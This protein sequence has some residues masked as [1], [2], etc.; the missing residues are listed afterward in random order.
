MIPHGVAGAVPA[1]TKPGPCPD[2]QTPAGPCG[3]RQTLLHG[4]GRLIV[5]CTA[6]T[7]RHAADNSR[8]P[9]SPAA[10][11]TPIRRD[12]AGHPRHGS[13]VSIGRIRYSWLLTVRDLAPARRCFGCPPGRVRARSGRGG[14]YGSG[15]AERVPAIGISVPF[16]HPGLP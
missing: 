5:I 13:A 11:N 1:L 4:G 16:D 2:G 3:E 9:Q 6:T 15:S 8:D 12:P 7:A 10:Q 14:C